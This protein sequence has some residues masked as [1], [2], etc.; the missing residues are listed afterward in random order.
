MF[1]AKILAVLMIIMSLIVIG[2]LIEDFIASVYMKKT[3]KFLVKQIEN[4]E[5]EEVEIL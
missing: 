3:Q 5:D 2:I 4:K 1:I